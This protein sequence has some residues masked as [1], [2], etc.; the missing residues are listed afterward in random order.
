M[1]ISF[2]VI[3][4]IP[5][6]ATFIIAFLSY[7]RN[8][9]HI[10]ARHFALLTLCIAFWDLSEVVKSMHVDLPLILFW[11][12][13][14]QCFANFLPPLCL[15]F[16]VRYSQTD[17]KEHKKY[18]YLGYFLSFLF[19][20]IT[21]HPRLFVKGMLHAHGLYLFVPGP[22][23]YFWILFYG[24]YFLYAFWVLAAYV[25]RVESIPE[26]NRSRYL[27]FGGGMGVLLGLTEFG[28]LI[29]RTWIP[30]GHFGSLIFCIVFFLA[31]FRYQMMDIRFAV[32]K[33]LIITATAT[34]LTGLYFLLVFS[35]E[36][37]MLKLTG[38]S[39]RIVSYISIMIFAVLFQPFQSRI[40][41]I[42]NKILFPVR[43]YY[44]QVLAEF[45]AKMNTYNQVENLSQD[46]VE[47]L[48]RLMTFDSVAFYYWNENF[49]HFN[50][51]S[52][53][54]AE[55]NGLAP[56]LDWAPDTANIIMLNDLQRRIRV[57]N[58]DLPQKEKVSESVGFLQKY[59][60][61]IFV[62]LVH[63]KQM[64]GF[65][66]LGKKRMYTIIDTEDLEILQSIA[67]SA[68][69][70]LSHMF[71]ERR[72]RISQRLSEVGQL[73]ASIA[74]EI[75]NPLG[76]I[77]SSA[78]LLKAG[79]GNSVQLDIILQES[80]RLNRILVDYL[81]FSRP[82]SLKLEI[83]EWNQFLRKV[84]SLF[85]FSGITMEFIP[86]TFPLQVQMDMDKIRQV[87]VNLFNNSKEA[88][89]GKGQ[90]RIMA[91][92][93][94]VFAGVNVEDNGTGFL[95]EA[96]RRAFEPFYTSK[97][98]GTGLGLAITKKIIEEHNG[99]IQI[100]KSALGGAWVEICLPLVREIK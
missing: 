35:S 57:E 29:F 75:K 49:K 63:K 46:L 74:H 37:L 2:G 24:V 97:K 26:K 52:C 22:Y 85:E 53:E 43:Y 38:E 4:I 70:A 73:S 96:E 81:D 47:G 32:R 12:K 31:I 27:L 11:Q 71:T 41:K 93:K 68:V 67:N 64:L 99:E 16:M 82:S 91:F 18:I 100:G 40:Y 7:F 84:I 9:R 33:G 30:L 20:I 92:S 42:G 34:F 6:I 59:Q 14:K 86:S 13:V 45:S 54:P 21:F 77:Q 56:I 51:I 65:L 76:A 23:Y 58:M 83:I 28:H 55:N 3:Y 78:Q 15:H 87:L 79:K 80:E 60:M 10:S 36:A 98:E 88:L 89:K 5:A 1:Q 69:S 72:Q 19:S 39:S 90:M 50:L 48:Q 8:K 94:D 62:P 95:K 44:K 66:L 25:N 61:E 17:I